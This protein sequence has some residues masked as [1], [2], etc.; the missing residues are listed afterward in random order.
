MFS[1][2][3]KE[4][5]QNIPESCSSEDRFFIGINNN[6]NQPHKVSISMFDGDTEILYQEMSLTQDSDTSS[7]A[8]DITT[9]GCYGETYSIR[10]NVDGRK[11]VERE[12]TAE[13][14]GFLA[15]NIH[16]NRISVVFS[17]AD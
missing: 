5:F 1:Q 2:S 8:E 10:V 3:D 15:V 12:F 14:G 16:S 11:P 6:H 7:D 17:F 13:T 4:E 9:A